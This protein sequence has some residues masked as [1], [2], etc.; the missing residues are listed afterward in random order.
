MF[1]RRIHLDVQIVSKPK[2]KYFRMAADGTSKGM[3]RKDKTVV[4]RVDRMY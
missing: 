1:V 2:K 4:A 3:P